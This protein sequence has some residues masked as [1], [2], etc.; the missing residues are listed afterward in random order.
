MD[1]H[2]FRNASLSDATRCFD[3]ETSAY[4][5][6]EAATLE[7]ISKRISNY[8]QGFL[9]LEVDKVV[10]GFINSGCAY[11]VEMSDEDFKELIGHDPAAPNVVIMSV[12]VDPGYQ[13]RGLSTALMSEFV[14][15]MTDTKKE[16]IHLMCKKHDVPLYEKFGYRYTQPSESD[17]GGVQWHEMM[18][19]LP[20][21]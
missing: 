5:G 20:K 13:G 9:I 19:E 11:D 12:V 14:K 8:P 7:K 16:T 10:V 21:A 4:D 2:K 6:D 15:R 17:H 18:M 3:V 1:N